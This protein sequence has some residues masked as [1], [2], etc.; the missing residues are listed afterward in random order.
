MATASGEARPDSLLRLPE[1]LA[2]LVGLTQHLV[3]LNEALIG[4]NPYTPIVVDLHVG[5][6]QTINLPVEAHQLELAQVSGDTAVTTKMFLLDGAG[7]Q[8][9]AGRLIAQIYM[10]INQPCPPLALN[11]PVRPGNNNQLIIT[12]SAP[13]ANGS[14]VITLSRTRPGG[15]PYAG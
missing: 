3:D 11:C 9:T 7:E 10:P 2:E 15:Y 5:T 12:T 14:C 6:S 8:G 1:M 13:V 4:R